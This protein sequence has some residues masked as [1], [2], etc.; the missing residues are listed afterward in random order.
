MIEAPAVNSKWD[1]TIGQEITSE[2]S[3]EELQ[4][5]SPIH[6]ESLSDSSDRQGF[7]LKFSGISWPSFGDKQAKQSDVKDVDLKEETIVNNE[8]DISPGQKKEEEREKSSSFGL[9]LPGL[10]NLPRFGRTSKTTTD[11]DTEGT[12]WIVRV[13]K[14]K[15]VFEKK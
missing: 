2:T 10:P 14:F 13:I 4:L 11:V 3:Q 5:P 6:D 7:R 9:R 8:E 15:K 1:I 12:Y